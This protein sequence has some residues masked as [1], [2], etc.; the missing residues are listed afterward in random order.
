MKKATF[1]IFLTCLVIMP[2]MAASR[3]FSVNVEGQTNHV[4]GIAY[5]ASAARMYFSFT[6][7]FIVTDTDS[8][9]VGS[10]DRIHGHLGA[11]TFDAKGRKVYASLEC[12][13]DEI[14]A[15]ISKGLGVEGFEESSF[16]IAEIDVDAI[17]RKDVPQD[18]AMRR[19][20]VPQANE[21][22]RAEVSVGGKTYRQRYGCT[23]ID[24]ITIGPDFGGRGGEFLYVAYGIKSD[25]TRMDN[26]Y[27]VLL[28][29]RMD[30]IRN[31]RSATPRRYF[32]KTGNTKYGV[33]N[34]AYD[35]FT[36]MMFLAVYKGAKR[37]YPN[38]DLF[39]V[40]MAA[41]PAKTK[42][43][44]VPYEKGKVDL[45]PLA[46]EGW[47]FKYGSMGLCPL[48]DGNWYIAE[49]GK[50]KDKLTGKK[51]RTGKAVLYRWIP[52]AETPF[53][54]V[55]AF[56]EQGSF[57]QKWSKGPRWLEDAV[58]YQIYPSSF[59]DS[60]GDGIGDLNGIE[61]KLDYIAS[62]GVKC[63]WLNPI[64]VS[65]FIDG[66]YDVIDFYRVDPRFGTNG[67]L[68]R[69]VKKA[70]EK[71]IKVMLDLV[72]G[73]T[74]IKC[75]WFRQSSEGP[76][77]R[78]SDYYIWSDRLP[79]KKAESTL[80]EMLQDPDYMQSTKGKW[81]VSDYP[82]NKYYM[83]N[84]YACQPALNYGFAQ[85]DPNRP[86]EQGV[87]DEG[88]R[89]VR[90]ELMNIMAFWFGK[91]VDGFRVDMANSLVK[92]DKN[93]KETMK[94]WRGIRQ[95]MDKK[96]PGR[97]IMAEWGNPSICL[98]A[99]FNVDMDL[100]PMNSATRLMYF[101][102]KHQ[103]DGG[104]YFSLN[105]GLS[106]EKDLYGNPWPE[107][108]INRSITAGVMLRNYY[109]HMTECLSSTSGYGWFATIT[110]NHDHLRMNTGGRNTPQ[111]LKVM[112][113]W[114]MCMPLPILYYGDEIGMRSLAGL[115]NVEGANH[116][117]KER[118][119]ART[120][121]QWEGGA[122]A[123]FSTCAPEKLYLPVCPYWTAACNY[124]DYLRQLAEGKV[125]ALAEGAPTV[126]SQENDPNSLLNWTK[127]LIALRKDNKAFQANS[128]FTPLAT[129]KAYPMMF[130]RSD[131][132]DTFIVAL[133]PTGKQQSAD[134]RSILPDGKSLETVLVSGNAKVSSSRLAMS[135]T[136]AIILKIK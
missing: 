83:K 11:I 13:N 21:D 39:A 27:Q 110:G 29:Y 131:G 127:K 19:I 106:S 107:N 103:A 115:P 2:V 51:L 24:G 4:Q 121:M 68:V 25:T 36:G 93:H 61:S 23:G 111:Q 47:H 16:Y 78:Y 53:K 118:A 33:Q 125:K 55:E 105:G 134:I 84:F 74:S 75:E 116:N 120:P 77:Q 9:I 48:G 130:S 112:M 136:S 104:S 46:S 108:Q 80:K 122:T 117:G 37:Q 43:Q 95:W 92:N 22:Y 91:G 18:E 71:G 132:K 113:T 96:Y 73:H 94:L 49:G 54:K 30:D 28:Q 41:I 133:N 42:L 128:S 63:I 135:A 98:A 65:D 58:I 32:I 34:L 67:D 129:D 7:R 10:V 109:A 85:P 99:G 114:V 101:D 88:P 15:N 31:G 102:N 76:D 79:D 26:D 69:L 100:N 126:Q 62:L 40:D 12:K 64:F 35:P 20:P 66:G 17:S 52:K 44:D 82:R 3:P 14:G 56:P 59:K 1:L 72:A 123:G 38:Y 86:W 90:Q 70:H 97:A 119:G 6:T 60:N 50:A 124:Q 45:V 81:M 89:A 87:N 5:D 8:R 57:K